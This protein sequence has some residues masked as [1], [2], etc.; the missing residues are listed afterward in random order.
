MEYF[1]NYEKGQVSINTYRKP[2]ATV[3]DIDDI[4]SAVENESDEVL[5][6]GLNDWIKEQGGDLEDDNLERVIED[7]FGLKMYDY[8]DLR[9]IQRDANEAE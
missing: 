7:E 5:V 4:R 6:A 8:P 3:T 9:D 1:V 2:N